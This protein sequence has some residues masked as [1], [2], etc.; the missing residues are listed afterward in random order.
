MGEALY[1]AGDPAQPEA[2]QKP[3]ELSRHLTFAREHPQVRGHVFFAAREVDADPIGAMARV[4]ADH[5]QRSAK[6]PR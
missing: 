2:W 1:K 6:P 4:V 3:A 5:Y